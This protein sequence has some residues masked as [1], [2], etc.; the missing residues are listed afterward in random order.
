MIRGKQGQPREDIG[1]YLPLLRAYVKEHLRREEAVRYP[2]GTGTGL[3]LAEAGP[4]VQS[5]EGPFPPDGAW[6]NLSGMESP[7]VQRYYRSWEKKRSVTR[8]FSSEVTRMA[9][10]Q[11]ARA[12]AFYLPAGIDKRTYG[13]LSEQEVCNRLK[14]RINGY[15]ST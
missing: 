8:T 13:R 2:K 6:K 12:S 11:F 3:G 15:R 4:D 9:E 5:G 10:E 1:Q 7:A 14:K